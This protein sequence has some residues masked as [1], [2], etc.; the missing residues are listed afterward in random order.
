M[1]QRGPRRGQGDPP[2]R[3]YEKARRRLNCSMDSVTLRRALATTRLAPLVAFP[4]RA[5]SVGVYDLRVMRYS[6]RWLI[7]SREHTNFTYDLT[8]LNMGQLAWFVANLTNR[9]VQTIRRYIDELLND[10]T[11]AQHITS[12]TLASRRR[13]IAD[14]VPRYGRRLGWYAIVRALQPDLVVETGTDKGMGSV[15]L[16][17]ALLRNGRGRLT[18]IDVNPA[19]GYLIGG[20]WAEVVDYV[21]GDSHAVLRDIQKSIGVFIHDSLHTVAHE[22]EEYRLIERNLTEESVVLSDNS[23]IDPTLMQWAEGRGWK[24]SFFQETPSKHWFPGGGIGA[25]RCER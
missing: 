14:L 18:T 11:L 8:D 17:A 9:D 12:A 2:A 13:G 10:R 7:Q 23:D 21:A 5:K 25:A 6:I 19:A 16:A 22:S 1:A 3:V 15:V 20:R 24:F 4:V